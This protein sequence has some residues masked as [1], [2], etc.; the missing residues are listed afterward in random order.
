[1]TAILDYEI[2]SCLI[3]GCS[4]NEIKL[5]KIS[6]GLGI[7]EDNGF[8]RLFLFM[9]YIMA[10][11]LYLFLLIISNNKIIVFIFL[12]TIIHY[13]VGYGFINDKA[14]MKNKHEYTKNIKK[15]N[16]LKRELNSRARQ[17]NSS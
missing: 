12:G 9:W 1:M 15:F 10:F 14:L 8:V 4:S 3:L 5:I 6:D 13:P 17:M 2:N 16:L 11:T 7:V